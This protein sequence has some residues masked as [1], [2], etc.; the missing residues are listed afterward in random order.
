MKKRHSI[1]LLTMLFTMVFLLV[2]CGDAKKLDI[3]SNPVVTSN[4]IVTS[5]PVGNTK[6]QVHFIDVG[7]GDCILVTSGKQSMLIDAGNNKDGNAV[8]QYLKSVGITSLDYVVGTHPDADHIGGL[9]VVIKKLDVKKVLMPKKQHTTKTF[10]DVLLAVKEKGLKIT[11]P[12]VGDQMMLGDATITVL[13]PAKSYED[14][15]N[16]SIVLKVE[17]GTT[18]FLM[19]GDAELEAELDELQS[20]YDL[21]S[22]VLKVGHHGSH[23]STSK[24]FLDAV[25]PT[26]AVISCGVDNSYGHP[27][28]ETM[29]NLQ[30]AKVTVYRTDEDKTIIMTS[31]GSS[32]E[33]KTKAPSASNSS[34]VATEYIGNLNSKKYHRSSCSSLPEEKNRIY[35]TSKEEATKKKYDPCGICNP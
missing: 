13:G 21:S 9:D 18:S 17:Y 28:V 14:N 16:N 32:L 20:G 22:T 7:Q 12:K 3:T 33:I 10:E 11:A 31:D 27:H 5:N 1:W 35:F 23:S 30:D 15:N 19:T 25:K 24:Q 34:E 29:N 26:Y 6:L 8:V 2:G 4:P